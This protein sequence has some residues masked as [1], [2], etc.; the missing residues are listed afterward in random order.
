MAKINF[1]VRP[2]RGEDDLAR[3]GA[4]A[5]DVFHFPPERFGVMMNSVGRQNARVIEAGGEMAGGLLL[6]PMGQYFGGRSVPMLGIA[7]VAVAP[8]FRATGAASALMRETLREYRAQG[9]AIST[10]YPAT[11]HVYR[12]AGYELA[13]AHFTYSLS[14]AAID[15]RERGLPVRPVTPADDKAIRRTYA[16]W[17]AAHPGNTDRSDH[18]WRR[19]HE[20]RGEKANGYVVEN[21][22]AIEGYLF[23]IQR[24]APASGGNSLPGNT[25]HFTDLVATTPQAG[26]RLLTFLADHRS[27]VTNLYWHGGPY[28][29]VLSLMSEL[30]AGITLRWNWMTRIVHVEKALSARGY[31]P[32]LSAEL[33]FDVRDDVLPE[34]NGRFVLRVRDG[35]G[36]AESGGRGSLAIDVRG[37]ASLFTGF[38]SPAALVAQGYLTGSTSELAAAAAVFAG[39]TPWLRDQF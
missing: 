15:I 39:P 6:I 16:A 30:T 33:H 11:V 13:G 17:A 1:T 18:M 32:L 21:G 23:Y 3:Y 26:R 8:E 35:V 20:L 28:E 12:R 22:G 25:L 37:L 27:L 24:N 14:P 10:L 31:S 9:G 4:L 19:V 38:A 2:T 34:N 29:S 36:I 7:L 5:A